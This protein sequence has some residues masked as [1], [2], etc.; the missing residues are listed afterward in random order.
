[1]S[2]QYVGIEYNKDCYFVALVTSLTV[3][4][5]NSPQEAYSVASSPYENANMI[6][7]KVAPTIPYGPSSVISVGIMDG[8]FICGKSALTR[9]TDTLKH[10]L[11]QNK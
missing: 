7:K 10:G 5:N 8:R 2:P 4:K 9:H 6:S 1:M 11:D 3:N